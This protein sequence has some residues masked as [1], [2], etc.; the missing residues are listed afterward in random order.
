MTVKHHPSA[1]SAI[2][3]GI[4]SALNSS[5]H[6]QSTPAY[7]VTRTIA[8]G[9]PDRWDYLTYDPQSHRVYVSH[10]DRVTVVDARDGNIVGQVEGMP[11][12]THGIAIATADGRGYTDD[13]KAGEAVSFDLKTLKVTRH[14]KAADDS[15]DIAFDSASRHVFI[16]NGDAGSLTVIDPKSDSAIATIN[17]G[18]KLE[19]AVSGE[20][21]KLYV[22]GA[23]K[24][25]I[26]RVDTRSNKVDAHWPIPDC[27]RPHGLA[28]DVV[29][30]RLFSSCVNSVMVVVNT[31][32]GTELAKLPIG[33]GTDAAS[34]DPKRRLAFSSNGV[35]GTL[36]V[37]EEKDSQTFVSVGEIKTAVSART[38]A[39][40]TE[41]GRIF[42]IAADLDALP[43]NAAPGARPVIV[44]GTVKLLFLD[45]SRP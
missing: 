11:G 35:D 28:I 42:L 39:V 32:T 31:D 21:G 30:H 4:A 5:A 8:I 43:A 2:A 15:D 14:I 37:I 23:G 17:L 38:M 27:E 40:D 6:A 1:L 36:S 25:E 26:V 19:T 34:F 18:G 9:A 22:N 33:R 16:V 10:G 20:N 29:N 41:S 3:L 24:N 13:G 12:G 7:A 45:P 44:P